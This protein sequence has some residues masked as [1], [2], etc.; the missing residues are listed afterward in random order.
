MAQFELFHGTDAA[1]INGFV[2]GETIPIA[3]GSLGLAMGRGDWLGT[4]VYFYEDP[5]SALAYAEEVAKRWANGEKVLKSSR[6]IEN[7][8]VVGARV[9]VEHCLDLTMPS[10]TRLLREL[11]PLFEQDLK[12][13]AE[14]EK[15]GR[16]SN[17]YE[18]YVIAMTSQGDR[19]LIRRP[20]KHKPSI[21]KLDFAF[22]NFVCDEIEKVRKTPVWSVRC[23]FQSG[24][25]VLEGS[26]IYDS[27]RIQVC[28]R[29]VPE[30]VES[31]FAWP[32]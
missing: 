13:R 17:E 20:P 21:R 12:I 11:A 23:A 18:A 22:I 14:V 4:G 30:A 16:P 3:S 26:E 25:P 7:P 8:A 31:F 1:N 5:Y 28:V 9:S 2:S 19:S 6:P 10:G 15:L 27:N 32:D 24:L 29:N